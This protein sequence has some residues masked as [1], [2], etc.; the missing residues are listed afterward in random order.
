MW[1]A[2]TVLATAAGRIVPRAGA[3]V[4]TT[5]RDSPGTTICGSI[6]QGPTTSSAIRRAS[7]CAPVDAAPAVPSGG[8]GVTGKFP[9]P[10]RVASTTDDGGPPPC[11]SACP[12][13]VLAQPATTSA[14]SDTA[15]N[16][17]SMAQPGRRLLIFRP[18]NNAN[19]S[20][21]NPTRVQ[22]PLASPRMVW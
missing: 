18:A 19:T 9:L 1:C 22:L 20:T 15:I 2:V 3:P 8:V 14:T 6:S 12:G 17:R 13:S 10:S 5:A 4:I 7:I 16:R 21:K 11:F